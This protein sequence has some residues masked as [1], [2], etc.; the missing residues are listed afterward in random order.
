MP[1]THIPFSLKG[2]T[3]ILL[4]A[5]IKPSKFLQLIETR[6][7]RKEVVFWWPSKQHVTRQA[8][9]MLARKEGTAARN[10]PPHPILFIF[11][12]PPSQ[13]LLAANTTN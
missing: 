2:E 5:H 3:L 7:A 1:K 4:E 10:D 6:G 8:P 9:L 13:A 11:P 12:L